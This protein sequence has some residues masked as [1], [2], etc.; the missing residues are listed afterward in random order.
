MFSKY[1]KICTHCQILNVIPT[2]I[3]QNICLYAVFSLHFFETE[4][5]PKGTLLN[6]VMSKMSSVSKLIL[7]ERNHDIFNCVYSSWENH[8]LNISITELTDSC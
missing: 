7:F 1:S 4:K 6:G 3:E 5:S 2:V 8:V